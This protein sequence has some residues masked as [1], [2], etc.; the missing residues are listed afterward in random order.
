MVF[1][2]ETLYSWPFSDVENDHL[3]SVCDAKNITRSNGFDDF[4]KKHEFENIVFLD[5]VK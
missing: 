5:S 2:L 3:Y 1:A 4:Q